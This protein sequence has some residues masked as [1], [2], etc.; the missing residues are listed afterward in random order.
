MG[1]YGG[2]MVSVTEVS[3]SPNLAVAKVFVSVFPS[4]KAEAALRLLNV[5]ALRTALAQRVRKQ[6]RIVPELTFVMDNSLN[7]AVRIDELLQ[8]DRGH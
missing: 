5:K 7:H 4:D 2:A 8:N 6:M 3:V 1:H